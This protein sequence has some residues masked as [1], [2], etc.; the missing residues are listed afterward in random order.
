MPQSEIAEH[1]GRGWKQTHAKALELGFDN[2]AMR[3]RDDEIEFL[4]INWPSMVAREIAKILGRTVGGVFR[5]AS[6]LNLVRSREEQNR[7]HTKSTKPI[8]FYEQR[9]W[10]EQDD[11]FLKDNFRTLS[12]ETIA[13]RLNRSHVAVEHRLFK[14]QKKVD[15][16]KK[17]FDQHFI[18]TWSAEDDAILRTNWGIL[19][20]NK[21]AQKLTKVTKSIKL[22]AARLGLPPYETATKCIAWSEAD[23]AYVKENIA[24]KTRKQIASELN[25]SNRSV[26]YMVRRIE[27]KEGNNPKVD[28]AA[29][30]IWTPEDKAYLINNWAVKS[31]S[32]IS[33]DLKRTIYSIESQARELGL[34][35]SQEQERQL[36]YNNLEDVSDSYATR[37][38][39]YDPGL[40]QELLKYPQVLNV[41]KAQFILNQKIKQ[42]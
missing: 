29:H 13:L 6:K 2:A 16:Y 33:Q 24:V 28:R 1:I 9:E 20:P 35:R 41:K 19:P 21:I 25:R 27:G 40:R 34:T 5:M 14:L 36:N 37:L 30:R 32:K 22:R 7:L 31:K 23:V 12:L 11:S 10:T 42:A 26:K 15:G 18:K 4:R 8:Q 17:T 3:W 39:T 38:I